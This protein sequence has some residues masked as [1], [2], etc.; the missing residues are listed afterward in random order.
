MGQVANALR[1]EIENLRLSDKALKKDIFAAYVEALD[2][3]E[4]LRKELHLVQ[5]A[6]SREIITSREYVADFS[7]RAEIHN[8][9]I[10]FLAEDF[11]R[12]LNWLNAQIEKAR[13]VELPSFIK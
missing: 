13:R 12:L 7:R 10:K 2:E 4:L 9:E 5:K 11:H 3:I 6:K 1:T 8:Q